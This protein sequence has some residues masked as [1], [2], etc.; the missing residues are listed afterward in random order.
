MMA[1]AK[2]SASSATAGTAN[3]IY[4]KLQAGPVAVLGAGIVGGQEA[5]AFRSRNNNIQLSRGGMVDVF[6]KTQNQLSRIQVPAAVAANTDNTY[7][8]DYKATI[9]T[10]VDTVAAGAVRVHGLAVSTG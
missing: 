1:R 10:L 6:V 7:D 5:S 4:N 9:N 2:Q 3:A 8:Y